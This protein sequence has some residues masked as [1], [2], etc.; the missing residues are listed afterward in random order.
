MVMD[1]VRDLPWIGDVDDHICGI[2]RTAEAP[3]TVSTPPAGDATAASCPRS[4]NEPRADEA[5]NG[6]D[7]GGL[8][9][10]QL[11]VPSGEGSPWHVHH[12]EDEWFYVIVGELEVLVGDRRVRAGAGDLAFG[13]RDVP[14]GFRVISSTPARVL[15][16]TVGGASRTSSQRTALR[17]SMACPTSPRRPTLKSLQLLR[18]GTGRR[19]LVL[20]RTEHRPFSGILARNRL[21]R[22]DLPGRS[23]E[24]RVAHAPVLRLRS[25]SGR[26]AAG[27]LFDVP[28]AV[29]RRRALRR[30]S[31]YHVLP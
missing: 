15:L 29:A 8:H 4:R 13:P 17:S 14:H 28:V 12:E 19:F 7:T 22:L 18:G 6:R 5:G 11:D 20:C 3:V 24:G 26:R 2:H 27:P 10:V 16:L 31:G 30:P 23:R 21:R 25:P 9:A 1:M